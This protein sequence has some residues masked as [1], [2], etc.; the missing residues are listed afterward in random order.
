M[1]TVVDSVTGNRIAETTIDAS[2]LHTLPFRFELGAM[3][4]AELQVK[5]PYNTLGRDN[6][7]PA[8]DCK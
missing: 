6:A 8:C 3:D 7:N 4:S 5:N 2:L 1:P